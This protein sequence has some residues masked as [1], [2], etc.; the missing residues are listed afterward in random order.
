[1]VGCAPTLPGF[2]AAV[3]TSVTVSEGATELYYL[4]YLYGFFASAAVYICLHKVFPVPAVDS[5]VRSSVSPEQLMVMY[6]DKWEDVHYESSQVMEGQLEKQ[7]ERIKVGE[8]GGN[9]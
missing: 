4:S 5:F 3:N 9:L 8:V 7:P 6:R 1:L 2:I